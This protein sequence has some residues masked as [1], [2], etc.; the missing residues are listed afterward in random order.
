VL[1]IA[2][3]TPNIDVKSKQ[4]VR[5]FSAI[6]KSMSK[7]EGFMSRDEMILG[8]L[9]LE[10]DRDDTEFDRMI[11][12]IKSTRGGHSILIEKLKN[13]SLS[14]KIDQN[15][16][17]NYTRFPLGVLKWAGWAKDVRKRVYGRS[18][19]FY[20]LT[21][22]GAMIATGLTNSFDLRGEDI[23]KLDKS[24]QKAVILISF[25][26]MLNESGFDVSEVFNDQNKDFKTVEQLYGEPTNILFSPFQEID[27]DY[28]QSLFPKIA[29]S[30][31]VDIQE[32]R[33]FSKTTDE[34]QNKIFKS[35]VQLKYGS[36]ESAR[37]ESDILSL[38]EKL[39]KKEK[40]I[41]A[42]VEVI[43][44]GF[45]EANKDVFYPFVSQLFRILGYDSEVSRAGMNYQRWD[46]IIIDDKKSIPI[47]IKSPGEE[48]FI[49]VKAV[50]QALENKIILLAREQYPTT[51]EATSLV[52]G[53][54]I[55]NDRSEVN[56]LISDIHKAFNVVIGVID[57]RSLL[58]LVGKMLLEGK[59]H[60]KDDLAKL[61]GIIDVTDVQTENT[62]A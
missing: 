9:S 23:K 62:K 13:L 54:H 47:E 29:G 5:P 49:S 43:K 32:K 53:Y 8:P 14:L 3:P 58:L 51:K 37:F 50:R 36:K 21:E 55:P 31:I 39:Y 25:Y 35:N 4:K 27:P 15:T 26:N 41:D 18:T 1:G 57:L 33:L 42:V 16:M 59:V 48:Q 10:N 44:E 6:I 40:N 56:G 22:Q 52:V 24:T 28:V 2:Y 61:Q 30:A 45:K 34:T 60:N 20:E 11:K 12:S 17:W 38:F 7:L 46:A 19:V